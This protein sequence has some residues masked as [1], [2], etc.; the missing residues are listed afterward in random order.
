MLKYEK[1]E[2]KLR[3]HQFLMGLDTSRFGTTHSNLLSRQTDLNLESVYSQTIQEERHLNVMRHEERTPTMG[4]SAV[5][6]ASSV[7]SSQQI[8]TNAQAAAVRF[9]RN[10]SVCS[11]CGKQG[12]EVSQCFEVIGYPEWWDKNAKPAAGRGM[13]KGGRGKGSDSQ[14]GR[15]RGRGTGFRA[16]NTQADTPGAQELQQTQGIPNFTNEQWAT[17]TQFVNSQKSNNSEKLGKKDKLVFFGKD[18]RY[19]INMT[20]VLLTI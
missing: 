20:L 19:D 16:Y 7:S 10:N 4:L 3:V 9:A 12:H 14:G 6:Q 18:S 15:G 11:H 17:L 8:M 1:K 2:E 13:D 5:T